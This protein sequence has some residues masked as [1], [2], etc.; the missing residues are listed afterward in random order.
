MDEGSSSS[1]LYSSQLQR[2]SGLD[3]ICVRNLDKFMFNLILKID[4]SKKI[5]ISYMRLSKGYIIKV[6]MNINLVLN[7]KA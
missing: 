1:D 5:M 7:N 3:Q 4:V 2:W 6:I